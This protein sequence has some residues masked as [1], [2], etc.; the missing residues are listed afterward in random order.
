MQ[1][2][3]P[4]ALAMVLSAVPALAHQPGHAPAAQ[5]SGEARDTQQSKPE[6]QTPKPAAPQQVKDADQPKPAAAP[7]AEGLPVNVRVEITITDQRGDGPPIVKTV[8]KTVADRTWGR[9]RTNAEVVTKFGFRQVVLNVDTFPRVL[10]PH[11][12]QNKLRVD[13]TIDYRPVAGE[14]DSEKGSIPVVNETLT[15]ILEDGKPMVISQSA[16][17]ATDRRVKVEAKATILK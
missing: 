1:R 8:S 6:P 10:P 11:V 4:I 14:A 12:A 3:A 13:M 2:I 16:D 17:P 9:I 7:T 5:K 15:V